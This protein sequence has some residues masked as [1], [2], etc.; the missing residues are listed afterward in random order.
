MLAAHDRRRLLQ[1]IIDDPA[2]T[3]VERTEAMRALGEINSGQPARS[4]RRGRNSNA[5][6]TQQDQDA[7]IENSFR[8]NDQLTTQDRIEIERSL[9]EST[10][11]ILHAL[12]NRILWL[13]AD[14]VSEIEL[15]IGLY[16][17]TQSDFVRGKTLEVIQHIASHSTIQAAKIEAQEFLG[18]FNL[19]PQQ[20]S[21]GIAT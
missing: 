1:L 9:D 18:E 21:K 13:F 14:N 11:Q 16:Q 20:T 4:Q 10:Q 3:T 15:M 6:Q 7:D 17:C 19:N 12:A 2:S 8:Y 5:P